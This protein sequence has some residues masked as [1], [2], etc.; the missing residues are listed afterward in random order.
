MDITLIPHTH[1]ESI[2]TLVPHGEINNANY[3]ELIEGVCQIMEAYHGNIVLDMSDISRLS[4]SGLAAL[5]SLAR[6]ASGGQA[7]DMQAGW[8]AIH[9][10]REDVD[11]GYA[12]CMKLCSP[13][14]QVR[15]FLQENS[16]S[17]ILDVYPDRQSALESFCIESARSS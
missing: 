13:Q 3:N 5:H 12:K 15:Q 11:R 4:L 16:M 10:L 9:D 6:I 17:C 7:E 2:I 14:P 1:C 8:Q